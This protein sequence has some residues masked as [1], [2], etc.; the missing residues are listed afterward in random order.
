MKRILFPLVITLACYSALMIG[1][2]LFVH[3]LFSRPTIMQLALEALILIPF[4]M[5]MLWVTTAWP[6][7]W[8]AKCVR[9]ETY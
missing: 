4:G 9:D 7:L 3:W 8:A 1:V 2:A 5:T 6:N